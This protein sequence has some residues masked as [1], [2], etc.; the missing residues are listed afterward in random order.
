MYYGVDVFGRSRYQASENEVEKL[1]ENVDKDLNMNFH[2]IINCS[3]PITDHD[4]ATK[5][6]VDSRRT[7]TSW[8][9]DGNALQTYGTLGSTNDYDVDVIRNNKSKLTKKY[10]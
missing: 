8:N 9:I 2:K 1:D 4:V 10:N 3:E 7:E 5:H 6:Y